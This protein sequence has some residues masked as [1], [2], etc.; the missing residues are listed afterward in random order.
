MFGLQIG[1]LMWDSESLVK[2]LPSPTH[3]M[4]TLC[5]AWASSRITTANATVRNDHLDDKSSIIS[6][7]RSSLTQEQKPPQHV[8]TQEHAPEKGTPEPQEARHHPQVSYKPAHFYCLCPTK[9]DNCNQEICDTIITFKDPSNGE[10]NLP[11]STWTTARNAMYYLA[12]QQRFHAELIHEPPESH[13]CFMDGDTKVNR[14]TKAELQAQLGNETEMRKIIAF[15]YRNYFKGVK[16]MYGAD[17]NLNCFASESMDMYLPYSSMKDDQAWYLSQTDLHL[18]A[19]LK[20]PFAFK[21]YDNVVV[22]NPSHNNEY[23]RNGQEGVGQL[24]Q[25]LAHQGFSEG[26]YKKPKKCVYR[27]HTVIFDM[28]FNKTHQFR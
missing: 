28:T 3:E 17:A 19:N 26:C 23:P 4:E 20:E 24:Q 18:R 2:F 21:I 1:R 9:N 16:Y 13:Y 22:R 6:I 15:N 7:S 10:L 8:G 27:N 14:V 25:Q 5:A 12:K 11:S